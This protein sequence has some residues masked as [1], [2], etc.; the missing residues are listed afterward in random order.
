MATKLKG[1]VEVDAA[2]AVRRAALERRQLDGAG[3][4]AKA[5]LDDAGEV[6]AR[7]GELRQVAELVDAGARGHGLLGD[8]VTVGR[9]DALAHGHD[10]GVLALEHLGD[11]RDQGALVERELGQ[12]H[13]VGGG[14][15]GGA[16]EPA[17]IAAHDLDEGHALEV[18]DVGVARDL[19]HGGRDEAGSAAV[20]GRVVDAHE[21]VVDGLGHAD[22]ANGGVD[23]SAVR[24]QL[25]D[26]VHGVVAADVEDGVEAAVGKGGECFLVELVGA[27][28]VE[29]RELEAAA[30]EPARRRAAEQLEG[31]SVRER[32]VERDRAAV[33]ESLDAEA[34]A[35]GLGAGLARARDNAGEARV[36]RGRRATG[37]SDQ[38]ALLC[39][40]CHGAPLAAGCLLPKEYRRR[41]AADGGE[42]R[43]CL[44]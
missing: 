20:A 11:V 8:E 1:L 28:G 12:Q 7:A 3:L 31:V 36:D 33:E 4:T 35:H 40:C 13:E 34:H 37:L 39:V 10:H 23:A 18:V 26:G 43:K 6:A 25:G 15:A 21:V 30:A 41:R 29:G 17:G 9:A 27:L 19:R 32:L 22:E 5:L 38:D 24:A 16:G 14:Q 44:S 42:W 2:R